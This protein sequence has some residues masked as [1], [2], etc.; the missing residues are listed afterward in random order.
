M[1]IEI[2]N[3][4]CNNKQMPLESINLRAREYRLSSH[5][6]LMGMQTF[7]E[8]MLKWFERTIKRVE[9]D[10][11]TKRSVCFFDI[12]AAEGCYINSALYQC[13][14]VDIVCFEPEESRKV[15]LLENIIKMINR[16]S[17]F[18]D[19]KKTNY[20]FEVHQ[21]IVSDGQS[22]TL[23]LRHYESTA[24]GGGAGSSTLIKKDRGVNRKHYDI[25]YDAVCLDDYIDRFD[26]VDILKIDVEGAECAVID[27]SIE[28]I[29]KFQPIIFLEVHT[30]ERFGSVTLD[31]V[32]KSF[33]KTGLESSYEYIL[34]EHRDDLEYY[35]LSLKENQK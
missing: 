8:T 2:F 35:M 19:S 26:Y 5:P 12:G 28:F 21:K 11:S 23:K 3:N 17:F 13:N 25:E 30:E 32:K 6:W 4:N 15:V 14:K 18:K 33:K 31:D 1:K 29:K 20:N 27:G 16:Y 10:L 9:D 34:I 22:P 7:P 24:T